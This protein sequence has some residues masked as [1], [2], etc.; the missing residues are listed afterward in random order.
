MQALAEHSTRGV[1]RKGTAKRPQGHSKD[2]PSEGQKQ[3]FLA[4]PEERK[5]RQEQMNR[6][7]EAVRSQEMQ[8]S[9]PKGGSLV[10]DG[11]SHLLQFLAASQKEKSKVA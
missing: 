10:G 4:P 6:T 2:Y 9:I 11:Q 7:S 5:P 1:R 3:A 8:S